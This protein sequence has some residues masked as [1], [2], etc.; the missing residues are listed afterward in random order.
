MHLVPQHSRH[1]L[2]APPAAEADS[3]E[4]PVDTDKIAYWACRPCGYGFIRDVSLYASGG[5]GRGSQG[6]GIGSQGMGRA[7]MEK[8][9]G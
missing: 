8:I 7:I 3:G 2:I 5:R 9:I 4:D 6:R 1:R